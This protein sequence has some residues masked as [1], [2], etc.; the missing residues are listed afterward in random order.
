[1]ILHCCLSLWLELQTLPLQALS[2]LK[3]I[4]IFAESRLLQRSSTTHVQTES[5]PDCRH[6]ALEC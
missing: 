2:V 1:M 4:Y 5:S 3:A 6:R